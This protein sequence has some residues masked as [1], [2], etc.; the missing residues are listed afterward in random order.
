MLICEWTG[1]E[2]LY[3]AIH[4]GLAQGNKVAEPFGLMAFSESEQDLQL[5]AEIFAADFYPPKILPPQSP[6]KKKEA[7]NTAWLFVR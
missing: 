2:E 1:L 4:E 5:C 7:E 6:N 3:Q